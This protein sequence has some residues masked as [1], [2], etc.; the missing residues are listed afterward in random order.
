M[1]GAG[2]EGSSAK[3]NASR[4]HGLENHEDYCLLVATV[5]TSIRHN[6]VLQVAPVVRARVGVLCLVLLRRRSFSPSTVRTLCPP[7]QLYFSCL[8]RYPGGN[9]SPL[10]NLVPP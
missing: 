6:T 8:I 9:L 4:R 10:P 3:T 7:L 2:G 1:G 5:T